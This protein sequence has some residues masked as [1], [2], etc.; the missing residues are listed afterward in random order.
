MAESTKRKRGRP[1]LGPAERKSAILKFRARD[2][3]VERMREAA[4]KTGRSVSEEIEH[5]LN[6]SFQTEDALTSALGGAAFRDM[7]L[8]VVTA[9]EGGARSEALYKDHSDWTASDWLSD[10]DC[11]REGMLSALN[12]LLRAMPSPTPDDVEFLKA[13][14]EMEVMSVLM[15]AGI[16]KFNFGD[17]PGGPVGSGFVPSTKENKS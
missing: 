16:L 2:D 4:G 7:T 9:F 8:G 12:Y 15:R 10:K 17:Q 5:R 11:Y 14:V 3:L 6:R 1:A 13:A